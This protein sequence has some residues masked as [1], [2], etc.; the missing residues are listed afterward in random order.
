[1]KGLGSGEN[2]EFTFLDAITLISFVVGLQNLDLNI[3]Q[4]NLDRQTADLKKEVDAEVRKA[5]EE[6]HSHLATQDAKLN[7]IM[8]RLGGETND[9]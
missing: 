2:G 8:E 7:I 6:I 1:M 9:R 4:D 3:T 5:L